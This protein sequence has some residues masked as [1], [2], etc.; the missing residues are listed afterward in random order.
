MLDDLWRAGKNAAETARQVVEQAAAETIDRQ[1]PAR[2]LLANILPAGVL[3]D[4]SKGRLSI[5]ESMLSQALSAALHGTTEVKAVRCQKNGMLLVLPR[6]RFTARWDVNVLVEIET[7]T[8]DRN[9]KKAALLFKS[10]HLRGDNLLGKVSAP[11]GN[12]ALF[13]LRRIYGGKIITSQIRRPEVRLDPGN[14]ARILVDL[15]QYLEQL[16][17]FSMLNRAVFDFVQIVGCEHVEGGLY[18]QGCLRSNS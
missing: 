13:L 11:A 17:R 14:P 16:D 12:L 9:D 18:L 5:P 3:E 1:Q 8:V 2:D 10:I 6:Q 15:S 7:L 4:L